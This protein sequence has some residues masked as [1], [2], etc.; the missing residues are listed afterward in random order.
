M[1][2]VFGIFNRNQKSIV[3]NAVQAMDH[4]LSYWEADDKGVWSEGS[5]FLGHRMLWNTP[6]SKLEHL[7]QSISP[8]NQTLVITIDARLDNRETLAEQ[9]EMTD[10]PL[11]KITDSDFILAAYRKWGESCPKYLLGDFVF[12][13]WD[14]AKEQLFCAR[15][16]MGIKPFYYHL[17]DDLF[18]FSNDIRGVIAH[19]QIS[20]KYN[21]R[22]I[23]MFIA[24][25]PGF[26]DKKDTFFKEIQKL[27][28]ATSL[29]ISKENVSESVFWSVE[30]ISEIHY[31]TYEAYVEKLRELLSDAVRVRLRT[32]YPAASHL[33]GGLDSSTV[34]VLAARELEKRDQPLYAFN[35][36]ETPTEQHDP[37]YYSEWG[38]AAQL[39]KLENIE[40][41][42]IKL[43]PEFIADSYDKV[44]ITQEDVTHFWSEY[45]VRDEAEKYNVRTFLSGWGGDDLISNNG[46]SYLPGLFRQGRF[47]KAIKVLS[48]PYKDKNYKYL[49]IFKRSLKELIYPFFNKK[50]F[51]LYKIEHDYDLFEFV[52]EPFSNSLKKFSFPAGYYRPGVH[53][54]QKVQLTGGHILFRIEN[55]AA[56]AYGK[57]LEYSYPLLDKRIAE[58][59]LAIPEDLF[60]LKNGHQR[61]FFRS[62][63]SDFLPENIVWEKKIGEAEHNTAQSKLW[64][65]SLRLWMLKNENSPENGNYLIDRAKIIKR[66]KTYFINK[67]NGIE[68]SLTGSSID[69]SIMLS[70]LENKGISSNRDKSE[71]RYPKTLKH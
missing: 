56:S 11:E 59:A 27:P 71:S 36:I 48:V 34:A 25:F 54:K 9:L 2:V 68:D 10:L 70:N 4:A 65:E 43:T 58:F 64:Y 18:V 30:D 22:S 55:W 16:H 46:Y 60:A 39:A 69:R 66:I 26:H 57:K 53:S 67:E 28:A 6:E 42:S 12:V 3:E 51:N 50:M 24:A 8:D 29:T 44:D 33:S 17:S 7:P 49:R 1:S 61:Y 62:A 14:A 5:V 13:I 31:D 41:K 47:V 38:F 52:Q 63:I 19:P 45:L 15:D 40:Q 32:A 35:W 21:E 20:E 23:A 37:T